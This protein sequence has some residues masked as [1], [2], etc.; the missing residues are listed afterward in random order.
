MSRPLNPVMSP[1]F[2]LVSLAAARRHGLHGSYLR[3]HAL[4]RLSYEAMHLAGS[5]TRP[6]T[7]MHS[8]E[9]ML[10]AGFGEL[11]GSARAGSRFLMQ[12]LVN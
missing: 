3:G 5:V 9:A 2:P 12:A 11:R 7:C 6:C 4:S 10:V 8:Y 1:A